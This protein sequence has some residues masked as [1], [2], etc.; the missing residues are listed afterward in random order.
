MKLGP[1]E[2]RGGEAARVVIGGGNTAL[3]AVRELIGLGVGTSR[4]STAA[5]RR[6]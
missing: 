5:T 4:C 1:V 3:D 2:P 6:R